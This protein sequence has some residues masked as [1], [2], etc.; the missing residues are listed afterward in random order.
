[1][2]P[3]SLAFVLLLLA[4]P[5]RADTVDN[6]IAHRLKSDHIPGLSLVVIRNGKVIKSRGYGLANVELNVRAD[7]NTVYPIASVTKQFVAT[8]ILLLKQ[9]GKIG[10]EDKVAGYLDDA[11]AVWKD[12]TIRQLL[13]H[14]SGIADVWNDLHADM[15][16]HTTPA[17][18]I[19]LVG[20]TPLLFTPGE[21]WNYSNTDYIVLAAIITKVGVVPFD[22]FL[23]QR[24]F[25]PLGMIHTRLFDPDAIIPKRAGGYVRRDGALFN[26][27]YLD[28][29]VEQGGDGG[30]ISTTAD[31]AKW[32]GA[33][34]NDR[35]LDASS[36]A[37]MW[38][39]TV[40]SGG[41]T[42]PY[43][44][45]WELHQDN[46][47]S[48][49]YHTGSRS[50]AQAIVSRFPDDE[51]SVVVL[52]NLVHANVVA[53]ARDVAG[54]YMPALA[55]PAYVSLKDKWPEVTKVAAAFLRSTASPEI[56]EN[57]L[58]TRLASQIGTRWEETRTDFVR[59]GAVRAIALVERKPEAK[60][61][62]ILYLYR[63]TYDDSRL[64][65]LIAIRDG[66]I[67]DF[68]VDR[69]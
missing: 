38:S 18:I 6:Y 1:M 57:V 5:A 51:I 64:L 56:D 7:E 55:G 2:R 24:V 69:E 23:T 14:T 66:H 58:T 59:L 62:R 63:V 12:V 43:G 53:I 48:W 29:S 33:L 67:D 8:G 37:M 16:L 3:F 65:F 19:Q 39:K 35:L 46:G 54:I 52:T 40:L 30:L 50:G 22:Q 27:E 13:N 45:G 36:R 10:L 32:S 15:H 61:E 44:F 9:D 47:H 28:P 4:V 17:K 49:I 41:A 21:K 42:R 25:Q 31:L 11:P 26:D 20:A 34:D 60:T 68:D